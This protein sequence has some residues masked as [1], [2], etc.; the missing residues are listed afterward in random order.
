MEW[1]NILSIILGAVGG[2]YGVVSNLLFYRT[3]RRLKEIEVDSAEIA[4]LTQ[5]NTKLS[6]EIKRLNEKVERCEKR[7]NEKDDTLGSLYRELEAKEASLHKFYKAVS[8]GHSCTNPSTECP[9]RK[10]LLQF[11]IELN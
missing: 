9:I 6:D 7:L 10:M 4:K 11:G 1:Y 3:N 8:S 2:F 5:I